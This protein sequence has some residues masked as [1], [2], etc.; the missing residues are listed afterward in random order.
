[1]L[2]VVVD[3]R[4]DGAGQQALAVAAQLLGQ[5]VNPLPKLT[6]F[7]RAILTRLLSAIATAR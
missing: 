5:D 6:L 4:E 3:A 2:D 1:M 7:P